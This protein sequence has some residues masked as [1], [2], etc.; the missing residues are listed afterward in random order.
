[1]LLVK[2]TA[3]TDAFLV[4]TEYFKNGACVH[5]WPNLNIF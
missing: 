2:M 4:K 5:I 3:R 1:M